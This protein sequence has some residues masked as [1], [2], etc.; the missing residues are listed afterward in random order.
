M[1]FLCFKIHTEETFWK[2]S[3]LWSLLMLRCRGRRSGSNVSNSTSSPINTPLCVEVSGVTRQ[4]REM[5]RSA[6]TTAELW[7]DEMLWYLLDISVSSETG[8]ALH[9]FY[10]P[11]VFVP[12]SSLF[13]RFSL[14]FLQLHV[15]ISTLDTA[16]P[17]CLEKQRRGT[18]EGTFFSLPINSLS[19]EKPLC[20]CSPANAISRCNTEII[21]PSSCFLQAWD[22]EMRAFKRHVNG[23]ALDGRHWLVHE[24]PSQRHVR[25][26]CTS[27]AF[28]KI[29]FFFLLL[30]II[31]NNK[32][33]WLVISK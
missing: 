16:P 22:E 30:L 8:F 18:R 3:V 2:A 28:V 11:S 4:P 17:A 20:K 19:L 21:N 12:P 29:S 5:K 24:T 15:V 9:N 10:S 6:L 23:F 27:A 32:Y 14:L 7:P 31:S 13:P 25:I 33:M 26:F 1:I